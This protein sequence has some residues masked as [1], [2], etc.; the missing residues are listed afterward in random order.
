[1]AAPSS[2]LARANSPIPIF[3][4]SGGRCLVYSA[5]AVIWL[6]KVHRILGVLIGSLPQFPQQ[7]VFQGLPLELQQEEAQLLCDKRIAFIVD[8]LVFHTNCLTSLNGSE[9]EKL[10]HDLEKQGAELARIHAKAKDRKSLEHRV[11]QEHRLSNN[12]QIS[13]DSA[14][15]DDT[16]FDDHVRKDH[17]PQ[18]PL[19]SPPTQ[20]HTYAITPATSYVPLLA[21]SLEAT[22]RN[23]AFNAASYALFKHLYE[24]SYFLSPGLRF[25]CRFLVYPGDPLRY[26]SHF[27][28]NSY[29]WDEEI[30]LL[31]IVSGGRLGTGVKKSFLVGG[32][33]LPNGERRIPREHSEDSEEKLTSTRTFCIEWGGM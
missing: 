1:M 3:Q 8:D 32:T 2:V 27:L 10:S 18:S 23:P 5:D 29:E 30:D 33:K 15:Q 4:I 24:Q 17:A 11:K 16:L 21:P 22:E 31:D 9:N 12:S 20:Q 13:S 26:H 14:D 6:R 25:G 28:A 7:N 19:P